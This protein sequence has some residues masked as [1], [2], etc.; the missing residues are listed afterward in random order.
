MLQA[1]SLLSLLVCV[2]S[3]HAAGLSRLTAGASTA[4][5]NSYPGCM[6]VLLISVS[7]HGA[8]A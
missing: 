8:D 2:K 1:Y 3:Q 7:I 4:R 5:L 6:F